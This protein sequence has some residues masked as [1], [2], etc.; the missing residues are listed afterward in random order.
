MARNN[1]SAPARTNPTGAG[2]DL[3]DGHRRLLALIMVG[4]MAAELLALFARWPLAQTAARAA[5]IGFFVLALPLV[6]M[7]EGYLIAVA[8]LLSA[9]LAATGPAPLAG[10][11]RGL[12][13][14]AF[15]VTFILSIGLLREAALTSPA[16]LTC[17]LFMTRQPA[18][19]RYI[20]VQLGASLMGAL[21]NLGALS[22]LAPLIQRGV[23]EDRGKGAAHYV[24]A[25]VRERRQLTALIRGFAW[26][27][28]WSPTTVTL[29]VL[30]AVIP[31][32][33]LLDLVAAG[34]CQSATMLLI[35]WVEDRIRFR[36]LRRLLSTRGWL[37]EVSP[38]RFPLKAFLA[39]ALVC[40]ALGGLTALFRYL[41]SV[42]TV[43]G[44]LLAA[45]VVLIGWVL[46]QN[47][48][49]G[50]ATAFAATGAQLALVSMRAIPA[51]AREAMTLSTSGYIGIVGATLVPMQAVAQGLGLEALPEWLFLLALPVLM[52]SA[53]QLGPSPVMM[54]ILLGTLI[55]SMPELPADPTLIAIALATGGAVA[56]TATPF[57]SG[58]IVL[59]RATGHP[60][61]SI[62]WRWNLPFALAAIAVLALLFP[63]LTGGQ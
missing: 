18:G 5:L 24:V 45:P 8:V 3:G 20:A 50:A 32:I 14:A 22:L 33:H 9:L 57:A 26:A 47:L 52:L 31:D 38:M 44:L 4:L 60:T 48:R 39:L 11:G 15:L 49:A 41:G 42:K 1:D 29:A 55:G 36:G 19:R 10:L 37:P 17:G 27:L 25:R 58:V 30:P 7:R 35:G 53:G 54:V 28:N 6:R 34:L 12:D 51:T 13:Q 59:S 56:T 46:A 23:R 63:L 62:S 40:V 61:T 16:I 43:P 2:L 21:I